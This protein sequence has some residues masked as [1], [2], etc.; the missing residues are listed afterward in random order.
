MSAFLRQGDAQRIVQGGHEIQKLRIAV[1]ARPLDGADNDADTIHLQRMQ[2]ET[3]HARERLDGRVGQGLNQDIVPRARHSRQTRHQGS[4][5]ARRQDYLVCRHFQLRI[6]RATRRPCAA[7]PVF[8]PAV[9]NRAE[10]GGRRL[11]R[12]PSTRH[13]NLEC[14]ATRGG[15]ATYMLP[16]PRSAE[17]TI[18]VAETRG[19][20][21]LRKL[22]RPTSPTSNPRRA[23]SWYPRVIVPTVTP[24]RQARSRWGG[25]RSPGLSLPVSRSAAIASANAL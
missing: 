6:W 5:A 22:P 7:A 9:R 4:M 16:L 20:G 18:G 17:G 14:D 3:E 19:A 12:P 8:R 2:F 11:E 23:A 24:N 25:S 10:R 21:P 1:A 13:R 15:V